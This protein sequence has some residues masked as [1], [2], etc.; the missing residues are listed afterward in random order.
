MTP[1][2][3]PGGLPGGF[4]EPS[5]V[6]PSFR[7]QERLSL[8]MEAKVIS[9][10]FTPGK[11]FNKQISM[12]EAPNCRASVSAVNSLIVVR[13]PTPTAYAAPLLHNSSSFE[14]KVPLSPGVVSLPVNFGA[15]LGLCA[16][17]LYPNHW[18]TLQ[19]RSAQSSLPRRQSASLT[20]T[21][22]AAGFSW[23]SPAASESGSA[24]GASIDNVSHWWLTHLL[25]CGF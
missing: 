13:K 22:A 15:T 9:K 2:V 16:A 19:G 17:C 23:T 25:T 4:L 7:A 5:G 8:L 20:P 12:S 3:P 10:V 1:G 21:R 24:C 18:S 14:S 11:A 6:E